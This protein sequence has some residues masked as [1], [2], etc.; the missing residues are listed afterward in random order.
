MPTYL[1][2]SYLP[3]LGPGAAAI[4]AALTGGGSGARHRWSVFLPE[5]EICFHVIDG[6]SEEAVREAALRAEL[7]YQRISRVL[8]LPANEKR[9]E[10]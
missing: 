6:P 4:V 2:E 10:R 7:R 8:P 9:G 5:D 3:K 1:V